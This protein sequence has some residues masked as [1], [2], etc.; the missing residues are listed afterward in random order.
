MVSADLSNGYLKV[1]GE[2]A[3][4][5]EGTLDDE[6]MDGIPGENV[7]VHFADGD[8]TLDQILKDNGFTG[9]GDYLP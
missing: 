5:F 2:V 6:N 8:T 9:V 1:N 3:F 4:T 7:T